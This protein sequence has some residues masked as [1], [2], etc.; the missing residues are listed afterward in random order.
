MRVSPG[1]RRVSA[2][3]KIKVG[4]QWFEW[5]QFACQAFDF[6]RIRN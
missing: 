3:L 5:A 4:G 6:E 2:W 1:T